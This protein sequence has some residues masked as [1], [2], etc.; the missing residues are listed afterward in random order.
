MKRRRMEMWIAL[1][2]GLSVAGCSTT[3][4]PA[5]KS[6]TQ[7]THGVGT[8]TETLVDTQR[9]TEAWGPRPQEPSRTLVTTIFYPAAGSV[10]SRPPGVGAAPDRS[11]GP[12]PLIVFA[13]GLGS[14]PLQYQKL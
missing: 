10:P 3:S 2:I 7:A 11:S 13:Q 5:T 8:L 4:S 1:T 12:Y 9:V 14:D 6:A